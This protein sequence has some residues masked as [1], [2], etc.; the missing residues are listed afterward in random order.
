M[1]L[2][3]SDRV[4]GIARDTAAQTRKA[5]RLL[6]FLLGVPY[7]IRTGVTAVRGLIFSLPPSTEPTAVH[8]R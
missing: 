1:G 3:S 6:G 8:P 4:G 7:R 5:Q 2:V